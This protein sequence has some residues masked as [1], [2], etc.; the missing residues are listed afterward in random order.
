MPCVRQR[1]CCFHFISRPQN[2]TS[3]TYPSNMILGSNRILR[4]SWPHGPPSLNKHTVYVIW[5][6]RNFEFTLQ[7]HNPLLV[8]RMETWKFFWFRECKLEFLYFYILKVSCK[9]KNTFIFVNSYQ[10]IFLSFYFTFI[11]LCLLENPVFF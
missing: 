7:I 4:D 3:S 10:V 9:P 6:T 1:W 11:Y 8:S 2:Y 5:K